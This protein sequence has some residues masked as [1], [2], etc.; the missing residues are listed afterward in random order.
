MLH[1]YKNGAIFSELENYRYSL[2]RIWNKENQIL[3]LYSTNNKSTDIEWT[4]CFLIG[5][6]RLYSL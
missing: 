2:W 6:V 4:L 5:I 1:D 3:C